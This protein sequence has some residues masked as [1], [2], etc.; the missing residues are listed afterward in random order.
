[1]RKFIA[2]FLVVCLL[3]VFSSCS[4]PSE[5]YLSYT[6]DFNESDI[7][8][9]SISEET[10][11]K[12]EPSSK[13]ETSSETKTSSQTTTSYQT[14]T[15]SE[16]EVPKESKEDLLPLGEGNSYSNIINSQGRIAYKDNWIFY[17][18]FLITMPYTK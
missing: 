13:I 2:L 7:S 6:S 14:V 16:T 9:E 4:K 17:S 1:M 10:P 11:S 8:Y 18:N 3:L 12:E 15:S 5:N